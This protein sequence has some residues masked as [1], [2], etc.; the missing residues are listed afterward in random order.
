MDVT[1]LEFSNIASILDCLRGILEVVAQK[2]D[3][4]FMDDQLLYCDNGD[5]SV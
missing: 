5:V 3:K 2:Y 4:A 1:A